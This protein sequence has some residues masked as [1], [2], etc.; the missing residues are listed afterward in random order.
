M[1]VGAVKSTLPLEVLVVFPV[2]AIGEE[3]DHP[4]LDVA[5]KLLERLV[6]LWV[7]AVPKRIEMNDALLER[8]RPGVVNVEDGRGVGSRHCFVDIDRLS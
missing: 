8:T 1:Q 6:V 4:G 5:V 3:G 7:E 2:E